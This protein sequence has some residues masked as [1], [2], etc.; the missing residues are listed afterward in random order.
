MPT[1]SS[2]RDVSFGLEIR[3]LSIEDV[4][5]AEIRREL[6]ELWI[7]HGLL[8]FRNGQSST[9]FQV[10]LSKVFGNLEHH[11]L[12]ELWVEGH[13]EII[14]LDATQ[15]L[16]KVEGVTLGGWQ[17]WHVDTI[18]TTKIARGGLLRAVQIPE[19]GGET[20]FI[21]RIEAY[22]S[23]SSKMKRE[24][25]HL[26][27]VYRF[28][29][30]LKDF[31]YA[32]R[33]SVEAA[34]RSVD[35]K[36]I[37]RRQSTDFPEIA[38]PLVYEQPGTGRKVLNLSPMFAIRVLGMDKAH[39]DALLRELVGHVEDES[40]AHYHRWQ[41]GDMVLWDNWRMLHNCLGT[42]YPEHRNMHRTTISGAL[43]IGRVID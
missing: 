20:G 23:L 9:E 25:D 36:A 8:I 5:N 16:F 17:P 40:R 34:A 22:E 21:D 42:T 32:T 6:N 4:E 43:E 27:I 29:N 37:G 39:S 19:E 13:P 14:G 28:S 35:Q 1:Y 12:K 11:P 7:K 24:I 15:F 30:N 41:D 38:A 18:Y 2:L 31:P 33:Q 3:D 10:A 26:E